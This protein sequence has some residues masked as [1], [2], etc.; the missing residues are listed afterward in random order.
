VN[1]S[2][3]NPVEIQEKLES[4][5]YPFAAV[6]PV[7]RFYIEEALPREEDLVFPVLGTRL[8]PDGPPSARLRLADFT[9]ADR[10]LRELPRLLTGLPTPPA[11]RTIEDCIQAARACTPPDGKA[12]PIWT[13]AIDAVVE[14]LGGLRRK[15]QETDKSA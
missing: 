9:A 8:D 6:A 3:Q 13:A 14:K 12:D 5:L 4:V 11:D 2:P 10:A 7:I 1:N 15:L